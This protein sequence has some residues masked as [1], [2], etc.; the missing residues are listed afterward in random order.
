MVIALRGRG[1]R[2]ERFCYPEGANYDAHGSTGYD[3]HIA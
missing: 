1:R 2:E 3:D